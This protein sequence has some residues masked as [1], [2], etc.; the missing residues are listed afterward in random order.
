MNACLG[1]PDNT[2]LHLLLQCFFILQLEAMGLRKRTLKATEYQ[3][4]L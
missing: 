2:R 3:C 1:H 4:A